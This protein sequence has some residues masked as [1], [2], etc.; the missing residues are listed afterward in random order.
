MRG[1]VT[2][3]PTQRRFAGHDPAAGADTGGTPWAGRTLTGTGFDDDTGSADIRLR[4]AIRAIGAG[5]A[6][7]PEVEEDLVLALRAARLLVPIVAVAAETSTDPRT[8]LVTD[9]ASDMA[10][11]TLTAADG[12]RALPVFSGTDALAAW[13]PEARPVPVTAE[14]AATAAVQENC[15]VL[16]IDPPGPQPPDSD[17]DG[18]SAGESDGARSGETRRRD[19]AGGP[20]SAGYTVRSSMIWAIAQSR[21]WHPAHRDL[22]VGEAVQQALTQARAAGEVRGHRLE[23]GTAGE[24]VIVIGVAPGA[25]SARIEQAVAEL[26]RRLA[27]DPEVRLRLDGVAI[28]LRPA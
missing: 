4:A 8:G 27:T 13:D 16:V 20:R 1:D 3:D 5:S 2:S 17:G 11:V 7:A 18:V 28:D 22:V 10:A 6:P 9:A 23:A 26:G 14:R 25:A 15:D 19:P 24:L 21:D 12:T